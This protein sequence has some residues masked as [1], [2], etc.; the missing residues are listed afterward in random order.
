MTDRQ[1]IKI[2]IQALHLKHISGLVRFILEVWVPTP[3]VAL[4]YHYDD[5]ESII[6]Q[7]HAVFILYLV[8]LNNEVIFTPESAQRD[9]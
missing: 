4:Y 3:Q 7:L 9:V 1:A 8:I 2:D 6:T 5:L